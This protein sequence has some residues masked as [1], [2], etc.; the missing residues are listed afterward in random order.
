MARTS[1]ATRWP[2]VAWTDPDAFTNRMRHLFEGDNLERLL[3]S[4]AWRPSVDISETAEEV[5]VTAELPGM[6]AED[7]EINLEENVLTLRGEKLEEHE[8]KV[9]GEKHVY[10]RHYGVFERSFVLPRTVDADKASAE[11]RKGLLTLRLPK[12]SSGKGRRINIGSSDA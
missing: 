6:A 11:F 8:D 9:E 1:R 10:E 4:S 5:V 3:P 12:T 2:L 7:I